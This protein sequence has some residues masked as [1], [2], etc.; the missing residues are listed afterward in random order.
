M[1]N[2]EVCCDGRT[3][4]AANFRVPPERELKPMS[5]TR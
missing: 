3:P 2:H 4:A 5:R 1:R